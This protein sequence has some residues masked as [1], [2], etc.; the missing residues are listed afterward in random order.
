MR[1]T[2]STDSIRSARRRFFEAGLPPRGLVSDTI[3]QSW[4]R[5]RALGLASDARLD[6]GPLE[7]AAVRALR[8]R[9][10]E[11]CRL[12]RPEMEALYTDAQATGSVV[13]LTAPDGL[14]LDAMGSADFLDKAARV[15]LRPGVTWSEDHTGT[16]AIGTA[17]HD[18]RAVEVRG[19]EHYFGAHR[20]LSC[21]ASPILDGRGRIVGLLDLSGE[22]SVHHVHALGMVRFAVDQ[23]ERRLL[24][25]ELAGREVIRLHADAAL[26]GTHREGVLVFEDHHLVAANRYAL[27]MLG[28]DWDEVGR[29]RYSS[30]FESAQPR[31]RGVQELRGPGGIAFQAQRDVI[32]AR[33]PRTARRS[34]APSTPT[35][36]IAPLFDDAMRDA[37]QRHARLLDA[38]IPV[39]LQGETGSGKEVAARELHRRSRRADAPFVAINCA[40]LPENLIESE[41]FGYRPGAFTG[42]RRE[43]ATGLLRDADGGVLFLDEIGDMPAALQTRLLRVLQEREIT[44]LGGGRATPVDFAVIAA[45]HRD[46][47]ADVESGRFRADLYY[48]IAQTTLCLPP[49]REQADLADRIT[50]LW[51]ALGG[52]DQNM[53]LAPQTLQHLA[54]L[55]WPGNMRQLIGALR[56]LL[57]LGTPGQTIT[58]EDLPANLQPA[59]ETGRAMPT[60]LADGDVPAMEQL[61]R[62]AMRAALDACHGNVSAAA[63]RL[64]ISRSTLYRKLGADATR[65]SAG[66]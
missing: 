64:G 16:N 19:A 4:N 53:P 58:P 41:L 43:G 6:A 36:R 32:P 37:L 10:E 20:V 34:A 50:Q 54:A 63:R 14:I 29:C 17:L 49:L 23:I 66:S 18:K 48:R 39:L 52:D 15:S 33:L 61:Q 62:E 7:Q 45:S 42:A 28:V 31:G 24:E 38:D 27:D 1:R 12:C 9:Y 65:T 13:M 44:P 51:R 25:R 5:C 56:T 59:R 21:S 2:L 40:A 57:A 35:K 47:A 11:L 46:V 30:L 26:L 8:E 55:S 3:A 60:R 22:A